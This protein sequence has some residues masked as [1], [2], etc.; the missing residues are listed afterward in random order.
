MKRSPKTRARPKVE[1]AAPTAIEA[2]PIPDEEAYRLCLEAIRGRRDK[3][4]RMRS[5]FDR[6]RQELNRFEALCHARVGDL[7]AELR[8][9]AAAVADAQARLEGLLSR[10]ERLTEEAVDAV[11]EGLDL[12]HDLDLDQTGRKAD[13]LLDGRPDAEDRPREPGDPATL[14]RLYRELAKRCHPD[15]AA[16][17]EERARRAILMQRVNEA[18]AEGNADLLR[19]LLHETEAEISGFAERSA[20]ERLR[21]AREEL[22][23]LDK[24]LAALRRDLLALHVSDLHRLWRRHEAGEAIFDELEDDLERRIRREGGRLDRLNA[25][26]RRL[27]AESGAL[28]A[29]SPPDNDSLSAGPPRHG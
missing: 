1:P 24:D 4:E 21:W 13:P 5:D 25:T 28:S 8:R 6:L 12:E 2:L 7:V 26:H 11:L 9:V 18:F 14:K 27:L 16:S 17:T 29:S 15:L 19:A 23:M 20:A 3:L 22:A 10:A